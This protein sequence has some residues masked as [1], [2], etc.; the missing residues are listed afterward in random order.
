M[1]SVSTAIDCDYSLTVH[2]WHG[3]GV[4]ECQY[5]RNV[6]FFVESLDIV[7]VLAFVKSE[8]TQLLL[9]NASN[10]TYQDTENF[11]LLIA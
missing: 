11:T 2:S 6:F 8:S 1:A 10:P 4:R 7:A 9:H 5:L 3:I